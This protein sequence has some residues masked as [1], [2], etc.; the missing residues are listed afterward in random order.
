MTVLFCSWFNNDRINIIMKKYSIL[1]IF[2]LIIVI[3]VVFF[4]IRSIDQL[5]NSYKD[6]FRLTHNQVQTSLSTNMSLCNSIKD[7]KLLPGD[8]LIR[9]YITK[10]TWLID[11]LAHPYFTH[12]A[13]YIGNDQI[14][15]AVGTEE[16]SQDDIQIA[17]LSESD[18]YNTDLNDFVI[19]R[20][21]NYSGK[22][23]I[24]ESNLKNIAND[25]EYI[26]GLPESGKK[27]TTCADLIFKELH[28]EGI[29]Q[30]KDA[31]QI[32]APDL[33]FSLLQ[34][35]SKEFNIVGYK[36]SY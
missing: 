11:K 1:K 14:I 26:F 12:S 34:K 35:N 8:I 6:I 24:I 27:K 31:P 9:R 25:P 28:N 29:I 15:E 30:T 19:I 32:I 18:W 5:Y 10:R 3:I 13:F 23:D 33:L 7:C 36:L 20:P 4:C 21:I 17:T 16:N 22:L 2:L